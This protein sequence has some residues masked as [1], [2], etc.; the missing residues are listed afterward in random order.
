MYGIRPCTIPPIDTGTD[1]T[2]EYSIIANLLL[3]VACVG[4]S[5]WLLVPWLVMYLLNT[6]LLLCLAIGMFV[7]PLPILHQN[8][9]NTIEYQM[10]RCLGFIPL[11]LAA[12]VAYFWLVIR[13]LFIEMGKGEKTE[14]DICCPIKMKTGVQIIGG[15]LSILSGV[16]LVLYFAKLDS[17]ISAKYQQSFG[18]EMSR[19]QLTLIAGSILLAV[20]VNILLILGGTG[21]KWRRALLLPWLLFYGAGIILCL[22]L[23]LYYTSLCWREE[24]IIGMVCLGSGFLFLVIW[25]LVWIVAAEMG[26]KQKTLISRPNPLGFQ[27]L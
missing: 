3:V 14:G 13:S 15:V 10:L 7:V 16:L 26:D 12:A 21:K 11:M 6:I 9:N 5:R 2:F 23:H 22:I 27:R 19:A 8:M 17:L 1:A 24:K 20:M 4:C 18:K 25:S